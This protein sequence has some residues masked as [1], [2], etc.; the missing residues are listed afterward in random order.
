MKHIVILILLAFLI[1][2]NSACNSDSNPIE[3]DPPEQPN[4]PD[5]SGEVSFTLS[6][7]TLGNT[8]S[9]GVAVADIDLDGDEDVFVPNYINASLLWINDGEGSFTLH[10]QTFGAGWTGTHFADIGDV[11]GDS[12]PDIILASHDVPSRLYL[13]NGG[14]SFTTS[15]QQFGGSGEHPHTV[16]L[17]DV[18]GDGDLDAYFCNGSTANRIWLNDGNGSFTMKEVEYQ[19]HNYYAKVL[20]DFNGDSLPDMYVCYEN[21]PSEIWLNDGGGNF[22]NS[23]YSLNGAGDHIHCADVDGDGDIDIVSGAPEITIWQNENN[24]GRFTLV[25]SLGEWAQD[26]C[27]LMQMVMVIA[28]WYQPALKMGTN[29]GLMIVEPSFHRVQFSEPHWFTALSAPI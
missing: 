14:N 3:V 11:N 27:Y 13:N 24:A 1:Q 23:G 7:Q 28:I 15:T 29:C 16:Q 26:H 4:N 12:Y 18:D 20:A 10:N 2:L 5:A 6:T 22:T 19:G 9:F 17:A 21:A 8:R 25:A